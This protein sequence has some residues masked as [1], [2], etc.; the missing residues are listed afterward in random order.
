MPRKRTSNTPRRA[1]QASSIA[2]LRK[3]GLTKSQAGK[4]GKR[5]GGSAYATLK[6]F[7]S[8]LQ[9]RAAVVSAPPSVAK[10]YK[11]LFRTTRTKIIVPKSPGETVRLGKNRQITK[12][13][14]AIPGEKPIRI[15]IPAK[16]TL[17]DLPRGRGY[18]Y[19][20]N[21]G[22]ARYIMSSYEE[23][24]QFLNSYDKGHQFNVGFIE[25]LPPGNG[26][27]DDDEE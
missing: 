19:R 20:V 3:L 17:E 9:G 1:Q 16:P 7:T 8:V 25:V 23:L 10:K 18:R 24:Q 11:S 4:P 27:D 6:K 21:L 22:T 2:R 14:I 15:I 5:P 26:E 12:R 13:K